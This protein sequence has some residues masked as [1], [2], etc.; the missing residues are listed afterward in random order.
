[1]TSARLQW[2]VTLAIAWLTSSPNLEIVTHCM[3]K[4]NVCLGERDMTFLT[5]CGNPLDLAF[6]MH[7][8]LLYCIWFDLE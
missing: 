7:L 3:L 6:S 8:L 4:C 5:V 2:D 1:M